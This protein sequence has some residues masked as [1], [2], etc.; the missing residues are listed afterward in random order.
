MHRYIHLLLF[1]LLLGRVVESINYA[2]LACNNGIAEITAPIDD[3][4]IPF[5]KLV[6]DTL[7]ADPNGRVVVPCG[8]CSIVD[9]DDGSTVNLP[10]GLNIVGR[11]HFPT[12]T[13]VK[14]STTVVYVQGLLD[15]PAPLDGGN[16]LTI[17]LYGNGT[18]W[19]TPYDGSTE[20]Q[21]VGK[22]PFVVAGGQI[23]VQARPMHCQSWTQLIEKVT[24]YKLRVSNDFANCLN[25]NDEILVT[26]SELLFFTDTTVCMLYLSF[27]AVSSRH[28]GTHINFYIFHL[29]DV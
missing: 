5:S 11:L 12:T 6:D 2:P 7:S 15:L 29:H 21:A 23:Y 25:W 24:D 27:F 3:S 14:I 26:S 1:P 4:C 16:E 8:T 18:Y 20:A 10:N 9:Y 19:F 28:F 17:H 22:K 13:N